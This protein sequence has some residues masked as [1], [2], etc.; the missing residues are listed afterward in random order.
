MGGE[1]AERRSRIPGAFVWTRESPVVTEDRVLPD[2]CMDLI[3]A[4]GVLLVAGPDTTANLSGPSATNYVGLRFAPGDAPAFLGVPASEL[5]DVRVPL[6]DL[7]SVSTARRL[8]DEVTGATDRDAA[9]EEIVLRLRRPPGR[10]ITGIV[11]VLSGGASVADTAV[12]VEMNER[13]LHRTC[14]EAFGYGPK[15]LARIL[16]LQRALGMAYAGVAFATVAAESGYA[17]QAHLS[18]DVRALA[19]VPLTTLIPRSV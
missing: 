13:R 8:A 12:A 1:Y 16:R 15:L 11:T 4:D 2:G 3:W 17:D 10:E 7:W 9:L 6:D 19:G 18:R 14:L 5:R